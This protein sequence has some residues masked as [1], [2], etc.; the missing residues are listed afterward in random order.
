MSN[1]RLVADIREALAELDTGGVRVLSKDEARRL[2][3]REQR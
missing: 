3:A 1:S 2:I